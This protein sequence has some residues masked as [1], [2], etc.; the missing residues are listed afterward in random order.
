[1]YV[2]NAAHASLACLGLR[3]SAGSAGALIEN[4]V[5]KIC[6][7]HPIEGQKKCWR[8]ADSLPLGRG[9]K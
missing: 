3:D 6:H 1:M 9:E 8:A 5:L 4:L 7:S 2:F